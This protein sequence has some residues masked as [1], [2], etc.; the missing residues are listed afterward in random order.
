MTQEETEWEREA[1]EITN[2][3]L[4]HS[5]LQHHHGVVSPEVVSPRSVRA[6]ICNNINGLDDYVAVVFPDSTALW[7]IKSNSKRCGCPFSARM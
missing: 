1:M 7:V 5:S 4:Q 3:L 6:K 2:A